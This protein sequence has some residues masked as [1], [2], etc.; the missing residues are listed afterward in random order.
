M[1]DGETQDA[2]EHELDESRRENAKL[3]ERIADLERKLEEALK[4]LDEALRAKR[5]QAAP[6]SKGDPVADPKRRGRKP[7]PCYGPKAHRPVPDHI[8]EVIPVTLPDHCLCG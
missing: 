1:A 2:R 8:D 3:K 5:R 7:G 4:K 6:F